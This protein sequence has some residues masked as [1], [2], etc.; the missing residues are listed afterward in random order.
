[1]DKLGFKISSATYHSGKSLHLWSCFLICK[2]RM[3]IAPTAVGFLRV[4]GSNSSRLFST[5]LC[6]A[7]MTVR[8]M[9][10]LWSYGCSEVK[11]S[12]VAQS[13]PTLC[14]PMDSS[15]PGSAV[16][17]IFQA[18]IL[19]WAA[20]SFSRDL[21]NPGIEPGSPAFQTRR[22]TVWATR[23]FCIQRWFTQPT[24]VPALILD[25]LKVLCKWL[26]L[27]YIPEG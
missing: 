7:G 14:N 3:I 16:H 17:G 12:E 4:K 8:W 21:P 6:G 13:C 22:F 10:C 11:W 20:I 2:I 15:L 24:L 18:R 23:K 1:M 27:F 26:L 9:R 19:E 25:I 5:V